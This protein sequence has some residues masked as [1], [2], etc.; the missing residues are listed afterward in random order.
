MSRRK[1]PSG[2]TRATVAQ[3]PV[4]GAPSLPLPGRTGPVPVRTE[5]SVK[6]ALSDPHGPD[7]VVPLRGGPGSSYTTWVGRRKTRKKK[8]TSNHGGVDTQGL[9]LMGTSGYLVAGGDGSQW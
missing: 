3:D 8:E 2:G 7:L 6:R 9:L 1:G 5:R 4:L